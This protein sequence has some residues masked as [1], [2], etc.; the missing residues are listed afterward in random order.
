MAFRD[1]LGNLYN[2]GRAA[3][4]DYFANL[5]NAAS[6]VRPDTGESLLTSFGLPESFNRG[7]QNLVSNLESNRDAYQANYGAPPGRL[8]FPTEV[9]QQAPVQPPP[10][11]A[12]QDGFSLTPDAAQNEAALSEARNMG[13]GM[14]QT[15]AI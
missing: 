13:L 5:T 9:P 1:F 4:A 8:T 14:D 7:A 2:T 11:Q 10:A 12:P 3:T 15:A 6:F